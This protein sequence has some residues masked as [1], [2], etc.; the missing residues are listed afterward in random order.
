MPVP[1]SLLLVVAL[2]LL[3]A[4]QT[5][6]RQPSTTTTGYATIPAPELRDLL[7][8]MAR[9]HDQKMKL[10]FYISLP[11]KGVDPPFS[12][13]FNKMGTQQRDLLAELNAWSQAHNTDL[14]YQSTTDIMGTAQKN[15]EDRQQAV[16]LGDNRTDLTRDTLLQMYMDYEFQISILQAL[17]PKVLDKDLKTYLEHSLKIHQDGSKEL[18]TFLKRYKAS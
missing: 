15:M 14:T 10:V 11:W 9:S 3:T 2:A 6:P 16:I 5:P 4:C 12:S 1:R 18:T 7:A 8:G 13:F 17:L